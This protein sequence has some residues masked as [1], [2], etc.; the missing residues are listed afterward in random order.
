MQEYGQNWEDI[1]SALQQAKSKDISYEKVLSSM[2]TYP[3][4]VAVEAH[5]IFI[6]SNMGDYGLFMGTYELEK[7]VLTMLGDL[8]HNSHPYGYLTTGGT[9][10]NIQAVRAMRNA[11]T[12]IKDPN[13]IVSGSA[14]FSF[15]KIA[16]ILKINVRK[17]RILPDLVVDTEDVL[18]LIDKNTVGL[19]GIA[20]S[21]EFGQVDPISE[22]SKIAI[23][24]DLPLHI[25][26]AFG[27]F[28]LPFLPNHVPFDFSLPGVT[29]IAIDPHKMGLS[30]I[31]S[32]ALLFREEKMMELLK[33]DTPYLTISS[34]CTLTG[35]RSGASVA[36]TYAV[37]KHLGKEGYQQVVN[38]CMKLTNLLLD[39][40]KNI[41]VKPVIDPVMNIVALSVEEP[42]KIRTE[43]A[44]QFGWQVSVTK[45][46]SSI[47][48]VVMPHMTEE[49]ILAFVRDLKTVIQQLQSS[50]INM[51][52]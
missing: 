15:D 13:I 42:K 36:S 44:T 6:E 31:P 11:C 37:M 16:D 12:S 7:S 21:T 4:P 45:Q 25:D 48:L 24:N 23:D 47:R 5:R 40:T 1:E 41:G 26:A 27:G 52:E 46:P 3:H 38:K 9:E 49:N 28:L 39:E 14:H 10:S 29:S 32:G 17:A 19:V 33:V 51:Q 34:Q 2:C 43:L 35:T 50:E 22:L 20:G 18:S 30:T 8:L